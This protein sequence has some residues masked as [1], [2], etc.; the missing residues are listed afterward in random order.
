MST[1]LSVIIP[2]YNTPKE[3]W[4]R[5]VESVVSALGPEDEVVVV[6]DGSKTYNPEADW[7]KDSRVRLVKL[8][9]NV[10]QAAARN[11][12]MLNAKGEWITF[13]DSDD[14]IDEHIYNKV[15]DALEPDVDVVVF[16]VRVV[17]TDERL[18]KEDVPPSRHCGRL[19]AEELEGLFSGCLYEYPVNK[20]FRRAFLEENRIKFDAGLC[21]GEDT[22][23]NLKCTLADAKYQ[24]VSTA[25]YVYYR[26]FT[27]SLARYQAQ[28]G[29]SLR[30]RNDLWKQL[31]LK[32]SG[33]AVTF[34]KLG[35]LTEE[36]L[37][38]WEIENVWRYDSPIKYM[39]RF[40][41]YG[42]A[43]VFVK[44]MIKSL[45][46]KY[47]YVRWIRRYKIKKMFPQAKELI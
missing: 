39:E 34:P 13:V 33:D 37:R 28:F 24:F 9:E 40:K 25:G 10:G 42:G 14:E 27:S 7:F 36:E 18:V 32:F 8:A 21:P 16:G 35:E 31:K 20:I 5:S 12:G 3:W 26:Y 41:K 46:R 44:M 30:V 2:G 19:S 38:S 43:K 47:F 23:F 11:V 22:V 17:W 6:D 15:F 45:M 29:E 1:R 4:R